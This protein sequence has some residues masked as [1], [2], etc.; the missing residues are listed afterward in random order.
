MDIFKERKK[1]HSSISWDNKEEAELKLDM[2]NQ[3]KLFCI[4]IL[5]WKLLGIYFLKILEKD[6]GS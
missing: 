5:Y 4:G 3:W 2:S 6:I 1:T